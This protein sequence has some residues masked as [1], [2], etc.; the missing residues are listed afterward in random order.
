[1]SSNNNNDPQNLAVASQAIMD[2]ISKQDEK[3]KI[4]A[5]LEL[6]KIYDIKV[7]ISGNERIVP[8]IELITEYPN[9]SYTKVMT[10]NETW[11]ESVKQVFQLADSEQDVIVGTMDYQ[12]ML[13]MISHRRKRA[14]E[15]VNALKNEIAGAEVVPDKTKTKKFFGMR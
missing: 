8:N 4:T 2:I 10:K 13:K 12:F 3:T 14:Q 7:N 9:V 6:L 15:I 5:L 11:R 1:M